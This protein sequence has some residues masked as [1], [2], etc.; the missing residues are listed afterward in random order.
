MNKK[1]I[2]SVL[3][4]IA[5][6][7]TTAQ[8]LVWQ[9]C[10]E[11]LPASTR[12]MPVSCQDNNHQ[13]GLPFDSGV[14]AT[15]DGNLSTNWHTA[16]Y[17]EHRK[18]TPETPAE[19]VYEFDGKERI[20]RMVYVPRQVGYNGNVTQAEVYVK[21]AEDGGE[22]CIGHFDWLPDSEEK[23]I[24]FPDGLR[25]LSVKVRVLSGVGELGSCAEM[26]FMQDDHSPLSSSLFAD[27]LL[28]KLKD[29]VTNQDIERER[30]PIFRELAKQLLDGTYSTAYRVATYECYDS[31]LWLAEQWKTPGKCYDILQGVT[32]ILM[33]PGSH[34]VMVSGL[35]GQQ[36]A[37]LK[38]VAWYTG[39]TGRNFDGGDPYIQTFSLKNGANIIEYDSSWSGLAY[40]SYFSDGHANECPPVSVHFVGGTVNGYLSPDMTNEQIHQMTAAA[41]S[42]FIDLVSQK[43]HTVWTSAGMHEF[44]KADDG[45]SLGYRQYMDILDTL[46][47]WEQRLVGFEKYNRIPRNRTLLYVNFTYGSLFQRDGLGISSHVDNESSLLNCRSL[48]YDESETIWG[49]SHEWGHQ[50]QVSPYFCWGGMTEVTNNINAYFN[51]MHMGY[52]YDQMDANKRRGLENAVRHY[53]DESTDDCILQSEDLFE[54]LSPFL[55]L[56]KYFT[57]EGGKPDYWPELYEALRN[58]DVQPD[59][60]NVVPYILNFIRQSSIVSGYD[61]TPYFE[62]FGILRIRDF[63]IEDYGQYHY[64]LTQEQLD[65]FRHSMRT[66][67]RKKK[68]KPMPVGM[69]ERIAHSPD[70]E[71]KRPF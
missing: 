59:S 26:K 45:K 49:L 50:H 14:E 69:T 3:F 37:S 41:R 23:T 4:V 24:H 9:K 19:L 62:H 7:P 21:T 30:V 38:V 51:V 66:L 35:G 13:E 16:Y 8:E 10:N 12:I 6:I 11:S 43:V 34:L 56:Y 15:I 70:I 40:I 52:R 5:A 25:P 64:H 53:I 68:L 18:V 60:T 46:M 71:Y 65:S 27:D 54:R 44:C 61:L 1:T 2:A 47:T 20:D 58:S 29:H 42:R 31:P 67:I 55:Q 22:H 36:K 39:S 28:T 57:N 17:P 63:A 32:G 48:I 33:E